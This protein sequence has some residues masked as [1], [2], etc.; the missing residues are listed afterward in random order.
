[1]LALKTILFATDFSQL[2]DEALDH[3][4]ALAHKHEAEL[5]ML[6][7]VVLHADDPNDPAHHFPDAEEVRLRLGEIA[8]DRMANQLETRNAGE[9]DV[10]RAQRRGMSTAPVILEYAEEIDADII[11]MAAAS[12]TT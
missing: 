2:A 11:V 6:H 4:L 1:M 9:L 8:D 7:A 12:A 3:A 10:V 5:H